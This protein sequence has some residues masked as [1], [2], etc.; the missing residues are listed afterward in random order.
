[1]SYF[2]T[3]TR[4]RIPILA[5]DHVCPWICGGSQLNITAD[6]TVGLSGDHRQ[7]SCQLLGCV[8][9]HGNRVDFQAFDVMCVDSA[10]CAVTSRHKVKTDDL[11]IQYVDSAH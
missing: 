5:V 11:N 3:R 7:E 8:R 2:A 4:H 9:T 6:Y 1:M 10:I